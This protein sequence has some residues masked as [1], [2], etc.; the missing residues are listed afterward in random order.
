MKRE[1]RDMKKESRDMKKEKTFFEKGKIF[2]ENKYR[3]MKKGKCNLFK[4]YCE[5]RYPYLG[6]ANM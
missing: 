5:M 1:S 3:G 4:A 6:F 2:F